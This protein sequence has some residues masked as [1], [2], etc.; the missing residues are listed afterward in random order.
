MFS[1]SVSAENWFKEM[2]HKR[3]INEFKMETIREY[4]RGGR[5]AYPKLFKCPNNELYLVTFWRDNNDKIWE[6]SKVTDEFKNL[7]DRLIFTRGVFGNGVSTQTQFKE[8][9]ILYLLDQ[10]EHGFTSFLVVIYSNGNVYY[11]KTR[12]LYEF[13]TRYGTYQTF[14]KAEDPNLSLIYRVPTGWMKSWSKKD[15]ISGYPMIFDQ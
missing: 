1:D 6:S 10:E 5:F 12:D 8:S 14:R 13:A 7:N 11:C 4:V 9:T 3:G 2:L 15:P